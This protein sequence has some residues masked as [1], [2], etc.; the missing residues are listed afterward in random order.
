MGELLSGVYN[1]HYVP[2]IAISKLF[3]SLNCMLIGLKFVF[4]LKRIVNFFI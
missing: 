2:L 3:S 1:A 4:Y